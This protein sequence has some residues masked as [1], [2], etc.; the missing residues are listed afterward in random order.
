MLRNRLGLAEFGA[1]VA[2]WDATH[3]SGS[4]APRRLAAGVRDRRRD[5]AQADDAL[6]RTTD[7]LGTP[8]ILVN[9]AGGT[10]YSELPRHPP[11]AG[12]P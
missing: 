5:A 7:E 8:T 10:F 3:A 11:T 6:A 12:T 1:R 2:V 9:N 4:P